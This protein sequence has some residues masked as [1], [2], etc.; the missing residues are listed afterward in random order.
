MKYFFRF[1]QRNQDHCAI[2][3]AVLSSFILMSLDQSPF[4]MAMKKGFSSGIASCEHVVMWIPRL[5]TLRKENLYLMEELGRLSAPH[6][7]VREVVQE[8]Q[9]LRELLGFKQHSAYDFVPAEIVGMGTIGI[10]GSIHLNIGSNEGCKK[11]MPLITHKG[12]VG[13]LIA[14][15]KS[16]SVGHLLADPN[17]RISAKVQRSRVLGIVRWLHGNICVLEGV[18]LRSDIQK[19][20]LIITSGYS[21]IFR[22]DCLLVGFMR[23]PQTEIRSFNQF[24][25]AR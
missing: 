19:G 14:V 1:L 21:R 10:P 4:L 2:V 12:V 18:P 25:S 13:K 15:S 20:D 8:N 6:S 3:M 7:R 24:Y 22:Q 17:F 9:R 23:F 5:V 16:T 11:D